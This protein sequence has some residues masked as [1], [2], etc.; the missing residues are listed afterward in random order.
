MFTIDSKTAQIDQ[1]EFTAYIQQQMVDLKPHLNDQSALQ[2]KLTEVGELFEAELT[3]MI[4]EGE[5][6]TV[7]RHTDPYDAVRNAKEGLIE[8]FVEI[9]NQINP[10]LRDEKLKYLSRHGSLYLH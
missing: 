1:K 6:Q 5:I 8:Y 2:V 4:S 3:A 10:H 9:E 7:G